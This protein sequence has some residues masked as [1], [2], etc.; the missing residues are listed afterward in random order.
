MQG[1]SFVTIKYRSEWEMKR[2][3]AT[4]Q[5]RRDRL[6]EY[7]RSRSEAIKGA[8]SFMLGFLMAGAHLFGQ[9]SPFGVALVAAAPPSYIIQVSLG[10]CLGYFVTGTISGSMK[11]FA[12]ILTAA[13]IKVLM[14]KRIHSSDHQQFFISI[15]ALFSMGLLSIL[16]L[17][18]STINVYTVVLAVTEAFISG[19]ISHFFARCF[20]LYENSVTAIE[21]KQDIVSVVLACCIL[22]ISTTG[23]TLGQFS[24]GRC[25]A[26]LIILICAYKGGAGFGSMAGVLTGISIGLYDLTLFPI[27]AAYGFAGLI[28]GLF[29]NA[30]R[31]ASAA[32]FVVINGML[33]LITGGDEG[34]LRLLYEVMVGSLIFMVI[35]RGMLVPFNFGR[36]FD[37]SPAKTDAKEIAVT[38]LSFAS[39]A[40]KDVSQAVEIVS[41]K[42]TDMDLTDISSVFITASQS[43]CKRCSLRSYCWETAYQTTM[44]AFNECIGKLR[45]DGKLRKED[46]PLYFSQKCIRLSDLAEQINRQYYRFS[47]RENARRRITEVR[48][49]VAEQFDGISEYLAQLSQ[50]FQEAQ[51]V[52]VATAKKVRSY[53]ERYDITPTSVTCTL[54]RYMRMS[55]EITVPTGEI[56]SMNRK[57]VGVDISELCDRIFDLPGVDRAGDVTKISLNEK[58]SFTV[59]FGSNQLSYG[60]GKFCGD[61]LEYFTDLKG[62]AHMVLSD[63]MGSGPSAAVDSAMAA[64]L[65]T[66]LVKAGFNF[67]SALKMVNSALLVKSVD[68]SLATVDIT[69][70]DLYTGQAQFIKAG[71]APTFVRKNGKAAMIEGDSLP[72]GILKGVDLFKKSARLSEDDIILMVS[73]GVTASGEDWVM[74]ELEAYRGRDMEQ[75]AARIC[76]MAKRRRIDGHDD[77]VSAIACVINRG[78]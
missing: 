4:K 11:Y 60:G 29:N 63:G 36:M 48:S 51:H 58:A 56:H 14:G 67:G 20:I 55:L 34:M 27:T 5:T 78:I 32:I 19:G 70:I 21:E 22:L 42:L 7:I 44:N 17:T 76:D 10:A 1:I 26:V 12:A 68:E 77:D 3:E 69:S 52:D 46:F 28:A 39:G 65:T 61:S 35:P 75:F 9:I 40:M 62:M 57:R 45:T 6:S 66:R 41:E 30:D 53:F 23:I 18:A 47:S 37:S 15:I 43:V 24:I 33:A 31:I 72:I 2:Q 38:K 71:A 8:L 73:D 74:L 54:D 49:I 64:S 50:E 13:A 16:T 59:D 25:I